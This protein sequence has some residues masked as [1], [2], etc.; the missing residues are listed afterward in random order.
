MF[1]CHDKQQILFILI[2]LISVIFIFELS[3]FDLMVQD[4]FYDFHSQKWII[5]R[6]SPVLKFIFYDGIKKL[7]ITIWAML[8]VIL[9]FYSKSKLVQEYKQGLFIVLFSAIM[10]PAVVGLLKGTTKVPCPRN[11]SDYNGKHPHVSVLQQ[12]PAN[13]YITKRIK[14]WPAGH[15]TGGFALLSLFFLFKRKRNKIIS[16]IAA[17]TLGW[18]MGT[19]K[20]LIGD[21]FLSHTIITMILSWLIIVVIAKIVNNHRFFI[22]YGK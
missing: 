4:Y 5:D 17:I 11:I 18:L 16:L 19:Y 12:Y 8:L 2:A 7:L 20:M 10:V 21:H 13:F 22:H 9:I 3:N 1:H 14:C 6:N 15:S